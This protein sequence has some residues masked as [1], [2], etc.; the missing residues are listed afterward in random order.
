[1][2]E[3]KSRYQLNFDYLETYQDPVED[4]TFEYCSFNLYE[5]NHYEIIHEMIDKWWLGNCTQL[6]VGTHIHDQELYQEFMDNIFPTKVEAL[7]I[8]HDEHLGE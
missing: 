1:M 3:Q 2:V 7:K 4:L 5:N 6:N 8:L